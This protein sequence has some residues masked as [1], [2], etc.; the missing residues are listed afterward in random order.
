MAVAPAAGYGAP[1][2]FGGGGGYAGGGA[3][4]FG[5]GGGGSYNP[6]G[7]AGGGGGG[8]YSGGGGGSFLNSAGN[9]GGGGS[10]YSGT[11]QVRTAAENTGN[12]EVTID[13][14]EPLC[15]LAGTRIATPDGDSAGIAPYHAEMPV[16][17]LSVGDAV[18]TQSG[19]A[20]RIIWI[21]KGRVLATRG[22][23]NAATPVIVRKG[24]LA[25]NVPHRELRVTK[26]HAIYIDD[27]FDAGGVP[28]QP[29]LDPVGRPRPGGRTVP[30]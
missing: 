12:G 4:G 11:N 28:D 19:V 30:Y 2:G 15:F 20:R 17:S 5:G 22:R 10:F 18:L 1:S 24:A 9:G 29:P 13:L 8:G 21:G 16:E 3:G 26:A 14:V 7:L 23:R 6:V 25:D 27:V